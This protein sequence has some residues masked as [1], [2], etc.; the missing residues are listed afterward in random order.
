MTVAVGFESHTNAAYWSRTSKNV[1]DAIFHRYGRR[2]V[3][4]VTSY[5]TLLNTLMYRVYL[6]IDYTKTLNIVLNT[7]IPSS[8]YQIFSSQLGT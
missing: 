6:K 8:K 2:P 7:A 1:D 3:L 4:Y 5:R